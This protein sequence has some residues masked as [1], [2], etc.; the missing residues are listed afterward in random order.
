M[1]PGEAAQPAADAAHEARVNQPYGQH[2][3]FQAHTADAYT[4]DGRAH[5]IGAWRAGNAPNARATVL[6]KHPAAD[7]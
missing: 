1:P 6:G 3:A 7:L 5:R 4:S 2:R